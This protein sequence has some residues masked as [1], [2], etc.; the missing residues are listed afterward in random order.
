MTVRT[1]SQTEVARALDCQAAHAF[2]YTGHL[3]GGDALRPKQIAPLLS[4]GRAWGAAMAA[5]HS[6]GADLQAAIAAATMSLN[7][8]ADRQREAGV[9]LREPYEELLGHLSGLLLHNHADGP[10]L[11]VNTDVEHELDVPIPSRTSARASSRYRFRAYVDAY[12]FTDHGVRL[13][14]YKLRKSL[15][16]VSMIALGRQFRWY[17]WAWGRSYGVEVEGIDVIERLNEVPKPARILKSG[18]PSHDKSQLCTVEA[19]LA[20][21]A[22]HDEEPHEDTLEALRARRWWQLVPIEFRQGE[23]REAGRELVSAARLIGQLD[24]G[25]TLPLRNAGH[26]CRWCDFKDICPAPDDAL[27]DTLFD[28][29]PP[30][31]DREEANATSNGDRP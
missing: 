18:K 31:R 21:C 25:R 8:D 27:V 22:E 11:R 30:K 1:L 29:V 13:V 16:P 24:S 6:T 3:S 26:R 15:Q 9:F 14:E 10:E 5:Y 28:R 2:R 4:G 7:D 20:V 17:S 23:L 19:Y 12:R